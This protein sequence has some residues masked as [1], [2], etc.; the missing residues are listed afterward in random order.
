MAP[1][2]YGWVSKRGAEFGP[3]GGPTAFTLQLPEPAPAETGTL[4]PAVSQPDPGQVQQPPQTLQQI[5]QRQQ[6]ESGAPAGQ[7]RIPTRGGF[8]NAPALRGG[9]GQSMGRAGFQGPPGATQLDRN[10]P[11][12]PSQR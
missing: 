8:Q 11:N 3:Q 9:Q 10:E 7:P 4:Q 6:R 1:T 5:Q 12:P 2:D